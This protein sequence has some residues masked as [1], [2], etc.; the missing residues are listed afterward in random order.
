MTRKYRDAGTGEYV[1]EEYA[2][3]N[4]GTTVAEDDSRVAEL[5]ERVAALEA[6]VEQLMEGSRPAKVRV[7]T[8]DGGELDLPGEDR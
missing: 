7:S 1:S 4:P 6:L 3:A 8:L 2:K 5:E